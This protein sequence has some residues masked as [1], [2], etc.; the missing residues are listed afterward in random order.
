QEISA[1]EVG[2][3]AFVYHIHWVHWACDGAGESPAPPIVAMMNESCCGILRMRPSLS[4]SS[5]SSLLQVLR[6]HR[7][8]NRMSK[9]TIFMTRTPTHR[10]PIWRAVANIFSATAPN[11]TGRKVKVDAA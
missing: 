9:I 8:G 7:K 6:W 11:A 4:Y 2:V 5:A 10:P 3:H 1:A